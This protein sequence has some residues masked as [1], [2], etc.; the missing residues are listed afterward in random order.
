MPKPGPA[1]TANLLADELNGAECGSCGHKLSAADAEEL[2]TKE[3][4]WR[5]VIDAISVKKYVLDDQKA[6]TYESELTEIFSQ[7]VLQDLMW[8][9]IAA[10]YDAAKKPMSRLRILELR[11]GFN[12]KAYDGL[13]GAHA[14]LLDSYGDSLLAGTTITPEDREHAVSL[15]TESLGILTL[16]FGSEHEYTTQVQDKLAQV[17]QKVA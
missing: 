14:W 4:K 15:Y 17:R 6:R 9:Q 5:E 2:A 1:K 13:S 10:Y 8:E 3:Q 16:M 11:R 7:H 12:A